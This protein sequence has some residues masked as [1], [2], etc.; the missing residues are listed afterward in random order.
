MAY[1][2]FIL[3]TMLLDSRTK[4]I[5]MNIMIKILILALFSSKYKKRCHLLPFSEVGHSKLL[6]N[7]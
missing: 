2:P 1:K 5:K 4:T 7:V 3:S 6:K